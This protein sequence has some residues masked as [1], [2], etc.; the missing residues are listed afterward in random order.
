MRK[1]GFVALGILLIGVQAHATFSRIAGMG[2]QSWMLSDDSNMWFNPVYVKD[3]GGR[4]WWEMGAGGQGATGYELIIN[5]WGG[6]SVGSNLF[7]A[8]GAFFARP[9]TG[10]T[11]L[12]GTD[13]PGV[14][15]MNDDVLSTADFV[16]INPL[17]G[18]T[19]RR[20]IYNMSAVAPSN[21]VDI[22]LGLPLYI[23]VA[24]QVNFAMGGGVNQYEYWTSPAKANND[25]WQRAQRYSYELNFTAGAHLGKLIPVLPIEVFGTFGIPII[26]NVYT[27]NAWKSAVSKF[28]SEN[29]VMT[30]QGAFNLSAGVRLPLKLAGLPVF[31]FGQYAINNLPVLLTS[32]RDNDAD[33]ALECDLRVERA[34]TSHTINGGIAVNSKLGKGLLVIAAGGNWTITGYTATETDPMESTPLVVWTNVWNRYNLTSTAI[35][36]PINIAYEHPLFWGLIGR[37]GVSYI[38]SWTNSEVIDGNYSAAD[39]KT[40]EVK[41]VAPAVATGAV[42]ISLGL[43]KEITES[44]SFDFVVR[45][46]GSAIPAYEG[47]LGMLITQATINW[48]FQ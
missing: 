11:G 7:G 46:T 30:S 36:L 20:N 3:L 16:G 1:A 17:L 10:I 42:A 23:P 45:Q 25:G 6:V 39:T 24:V 40:S 18:L 27:E 28:Y 35:S 2:L 13:A 41:V 29:T 32:K 38:P 15:G 14:L 5:Q 9:Y 37:A 8:V 48:K 26:D 4:A 31:V 22:F 44:L 34:I 21:M 47:L 33:A 12:A 19:N 43:S